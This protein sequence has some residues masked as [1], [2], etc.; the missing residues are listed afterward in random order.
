M[1]DRD[2]IDGGDAMTTPGP[3]STAIADNEDFGRSRWLL[4]PSASQPILLFFPPRRRD[5]E[6]RE[7]IGFDFGE[8][9]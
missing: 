8:A 2:D 1:V 7:E 3:P 4:Q 5:E 6:C 9:T